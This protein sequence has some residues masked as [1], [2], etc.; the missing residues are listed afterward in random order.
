MSDKLLSAD[1]DK[2]SEIC[3]SVVIKRV[4]YGRNGKSIYIHVTSREPKFSFRYKMISDI[5]KSKDFNINRV[6]SYSIL[7]KIFDKM[8][9]RPKQFDFNEWYTWK[10]QIEREVIQKSKK[11]IVTLHKHISDM[12]EALQKS[13]EGPKKRHE[14]AIYSA[15]LRLRAPLM[16]AEKA[17]LCLDDIVDLWN[18]TIVK[19]II[20]S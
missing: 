14:A 9:P 6:F 16:R 1:V 17:G 11:H 20:N 18:T 7:N 19:N 10:N 8:Y 5:S 2:I 12:F 13:N 3:K 15:K 4:Y